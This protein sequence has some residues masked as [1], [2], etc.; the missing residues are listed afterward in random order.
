VR[1][2]L[3]AA[4]IALAGC[5]FD[6]PTLGGTIVSVVE[7]ERA[8]EFSAREESGKRY[9]DDLLVPEVAWKVEVHLDNGAAVT[10]IQNGPRRY[11]PGTRVRLLQH[12]DGALLL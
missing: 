3:A 5:Q 4:I 7:A 2:I 6:E 9:D 11:V 8:E 1:A 12:E 10:V